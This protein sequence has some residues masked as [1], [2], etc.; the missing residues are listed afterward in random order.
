VAKTVA[1]MADARGA[2][3]VACLAEAPVERDDAQA[4]AGVQENARG[5]PRSRPLVLR[6][7]LSRP[8]YGSENSCVCGFRYGSLSAPP[9]WRPLKRN[10]FTPLVISDS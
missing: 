5:R 1:K 8:R 4:A 3:T 7:E 2:L 6:L 10:T 9:V